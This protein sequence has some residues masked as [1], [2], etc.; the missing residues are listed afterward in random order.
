MH[1]KNVRVLNANAIKFLAA[2][3][4]VID[5]VGLLF[6]PQTAIFRYIGRV[7]MPL[8]AF[9][10]SEGCRYTK[11]KTKHFA[12]MFGLALLCQIVY[13]VAMHSLYMCILVT[14]SLSVLTIYALQNFKKSLF[15][16]GLF[17]EKVL[18]GSVLA[19]TVLLVWRVCSVLEVDYG[20]WGCM[21]PVF[22]SVFDFRGI[23]NVPNALKKWDC[24][25]ARIACMGVGLLLLCF[26]YY[27]ASS[28][29][30]ALLSLP[31]LMLYNGEK[32]KANTKYFFYV[33]YPA[34]L[35]FL[36]GLFWLLQIL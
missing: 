24:L 20:F 34:H 8:F 28:P 6:F 13:Y 22:A 5:H 21:L 11:N 17:K 9:A 30:F 7:S 14:F 12:L 15:E 26:S 1:M 2:A 16:N 4:M 25:P 19:V 36:Q 29:F 27:P 31:V 32:G 10:V 3:I 35:V 18:S 33:F 23:E